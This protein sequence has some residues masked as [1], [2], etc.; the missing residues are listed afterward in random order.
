M[1][2]S[3]ACITQGLSHDDGSVH[4]SSQVEVKFTLEQAIEGP[5]GE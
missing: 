4:D 1:A 3:I 5:D 2:E